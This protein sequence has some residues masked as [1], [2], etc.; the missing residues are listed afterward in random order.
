[1]RPPDRPL[2]AVAISVVVASVGV[3]VAIAVAVAAGG[4]VAVVFLALGG[5]WLLG[6]GSAAWTLAV[7]RARRTKATVPSPSRRGAFI[8]RPLGVPPWQPEPRRAPGGPGATTPRPSGS[9]APTASQ[10]TAYA[11]A[12]RMIRSAE[13]AGTVTTPEA[14]CIRD[15]CDAL[16]F[17]EDDASE[18][19]ALATAVLADV[20]RTTPRRRGRT[21]GAAAL[22]NVVEACRAPGGRATRQ[23]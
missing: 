21:D 3:I 19:L 12:M 15:A 22:R 14:Q 11:E 2:G 9:Y 5:G 13:A 8:E 18:T 7:R 17:A 16:F 4:D 1:M 6:W 23:A 10:R 20:A